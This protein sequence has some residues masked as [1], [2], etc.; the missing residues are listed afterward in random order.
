MIYVKSKIENYE[1][2]QVD[3]LGNVYSCKR[4]SCVKM[5]PQYVG[6]GYQYVTLC[7]NGERKNQ[8]I[9]R[10]VAQAFIM[11]HQNKQQVNHIDGNK[12]N[13]RRDNL[14]WVTPS[15]NIIHAQKIGKIRVTEKMREATRL[16]SIKKTRDKLTGKIYE[17][18][19]SAC[20]DTKQNYFNT[21]SKI[22]KKSPNCRFE[23][24]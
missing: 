21:N 23:Y 7:K 6:G 1:D 9:H 13:N 16:R 10:L 22:Y 8:F 5:K 24:I 14:E 20:L 19:K 18:L 12:T 2:Y 3:T 11:N 17:S 4:G 15:E